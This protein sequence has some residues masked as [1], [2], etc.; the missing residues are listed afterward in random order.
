M[1]RIIEALREGSKSRLIVGTA[2]SPTLPAHTQMAIPVSIG[3]NKLLL[4]SVEVTC[5][6]QADFRV[7]FFEE[8]SQSHSRYNS[9]IVTGE[10]Y[11]VLDLP[12]IDQANSGTMYF[13]VSNES[14][15]DASYT[16]EVRGIEMK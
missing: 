7:E 14:D 8:P 16:L 12:Y 3:V 10:N 13:L 9:G 5:S 2:S 11:D 1:N 15:G 4:K 6:K